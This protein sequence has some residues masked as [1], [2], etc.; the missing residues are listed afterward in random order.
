MLKLKQ[1]FTP[2]NDFVLLENETIININEV[3]VIIKIIGK[4]NFAIRL[5]YDYNNMNDNIVQLN[6]KSKQQLETSFNFLQKKLIG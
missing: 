2:K 5:C 6:F 4:D 1:L 3:K